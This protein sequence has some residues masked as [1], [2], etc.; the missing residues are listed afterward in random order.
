FSA[1]AVAGLALPAEGM[2]GD[3]HGT[4]AYRAHLVKVMTGR[5]VTAAS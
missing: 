3:M 4:P 5:A 2:I 1:E